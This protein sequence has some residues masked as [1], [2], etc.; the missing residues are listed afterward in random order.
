VSRE[1]LEYIAR[2]ITEQEDSIVN[3]L[4][5][6]RCKDFSDYKYSAGILRGCH[7]VKGILLE[8]REKM[9]KDEE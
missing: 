2:K 6:G 3:D 7:L 4:Q 5:L 1:L 9:E 8:V